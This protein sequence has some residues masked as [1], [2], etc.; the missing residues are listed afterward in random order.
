MVNSRYLRYSTIVQ[1]VH[2]KIVPTQIK[3]ALLGCTL[4]SLTGLLVSCGGSSSGGIYNQV[5]NVS[6][7]RSGQI[8]DG[9]LSRVINVTLNQNTTAI[10]GIIIV[11]GH[12]CISSR[13]LSGT[14]TQNTVNN[15]GDNPLT[16]DQENSNT[17]AAD[18]VIAITETVGEAEITHNINFTLIGSS[19]LLTG[20]YAGTWIPEK[21]ADGDDLEIPG[22]ENAT[23]RTG[24]E[25]SIQL[26]RI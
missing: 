13:N 23:C 21:D 19:K 18:L 5:F 7:Q 8:G 24:I 1:I 9:N 26:S 11:T 20:Q 16:G 2:Q 14:A 17:G 3:K 4:L 10:S 15:T 22:D 6:G 25:G 12:S